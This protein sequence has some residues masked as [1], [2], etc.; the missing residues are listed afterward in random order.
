MYGAFKMKLCTN[1]SIPCEYLKGACIFLSDEDEGRYIKDVCVDLEKHSI[2]LID[3]DGNGLY[4][5]SL[6]NASIQFQGGR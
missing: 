1:Q 6:R 3:D 2:I 4:W 5:E